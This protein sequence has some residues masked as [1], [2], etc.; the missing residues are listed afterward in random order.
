MRQI[1]PQE[2]LDYD[3]VFESISNDALQRKLSDEQV[4]KIWQ[5]GIASTQTRPILSR[6]LCWLGFHSCE[7][8][9]DICHCRCV[10]CGAEWIENPYIL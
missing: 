10:R 4:W 6:L 3:D 2:N 9:I 8:T 5:A 7:N 1:E